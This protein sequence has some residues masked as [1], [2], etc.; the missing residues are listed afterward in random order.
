MLSFTGV[1]LALYLRDGFVPRRGWQPPYRHAWETKDGKFVVVTNPEFHLWER[2]CK[3]IEREDLIPKQRPKGEER[4]RINDEIARIMR[5]KTREE[6]VT[7]FRGAGVSAAPLHEIDEVAAEGHFL[8]RGMIVGHSHS[9]LGAVNQLETPI[10]L[11]GAPPQFRNFAPR[12]G[13]HTEDI[14]I[15][16]GYSKEEIQAMRAAGAVK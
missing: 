5:T 15:S 3:A 11:S 12:L 8:E 1:N 2:F 14:M 16:L 10:K 9:A 4:R 13:E 6:W 7:I